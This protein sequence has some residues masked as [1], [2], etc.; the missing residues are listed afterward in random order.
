MIGELLVLP[1][2]EAKEL[3]CT[4]PADIG[5]TIV[6]VVNGSQLSAEET[7]FRSEDIISAN[8]S[9]GMNL[10]FTATSEVN[11]TNVHCLIIDIQRLL[12]SKSSQFSIQ[13]QGMKY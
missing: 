12:A 4:A 9:R 8:M 3:L 6:W 1:L 10:K 5:Y 13:I 11:N 2:G 7:N